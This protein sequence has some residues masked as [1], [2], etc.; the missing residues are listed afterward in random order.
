MSAAN[1]SSILLVDD[2]LMSIA[3]LRQALSE[4]GQLRFATSGSDALRLA[5]QRVPDLVLLDVEMPGMTGF[6]VCTAMKQDPVLRDVPIIFITSHD[7]IE[8][9]VTGLSLGAADFIAK[10]P[11]APLVIARVR[12]QLAMKAMADALRRAATTDGLTG[13]ANRRAFDERIEGEWARCHRSHAPLSLLMIDVDCFKAYN[14][15]YGHPAGDQ[16]LAAVAGAIGSAARRPGDLCAR[17]GGEEFSVLLPD[18]HRA[19]AWQI[20][21]RLL[22]HLDDRRLPHIASSVADHVTISIG[23]ATFQAP[24]DADEAAARQA[25]GRDARALIAAADQGLYAAKHAG[26]HCARFVALAREAAPAVDLGTLTATSGRL[27]LLP[28]LETPR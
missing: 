14:D 26:R 7:A 12:T 20:A 15:R 19:G 21:H 16:C 11:R 22:A 6:E 2:D 23:V 1:T 9:E 10:P 8:Q 17:Y 18:T 27:P 24:N 3:T 4:V 25:P 5:R 13:L 28:P